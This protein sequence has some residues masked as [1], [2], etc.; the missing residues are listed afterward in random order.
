MI[1]AMQEVVA[2]ALPDTAPKMAQATMVT[3]PKATLDPLLN[4]S[5][6]SIQLFADTT[7]ID[8]GTSHNE[9]WNGQQQNSVL[10]AGNP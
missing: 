6:P 7:L 8:N 9:Q 2:E 4:R 1:E 5:K 3:V 10:H